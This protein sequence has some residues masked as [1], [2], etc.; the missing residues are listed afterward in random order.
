MESLS[1]MNEWMEKYKDLFIYIYIYIR[2]ATEMYEWKSKIHNIIMTKLLNIIPINSTVENVPQ[3]ILLQHIHTYTHEEHHFA[4][5][6]VVRRYSTPPF[7]PNYHLAGWLCKGWICGSY[8]GERDEVKWGD[9]YVQ[10]LNKLFGVIVQE[11]EQEE[12]VVVVVVSSSNTTTLYVRLLN[13][14]SLTSNRLQWLLIL[15]KPATFTI[16]I[17]L[18]FYCS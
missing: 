5:S 13:L 10:F 16:A 7:I 18:I 9:G 2:I 11:E 15:W 3:I 12:E 17:E 1:I 4:F 6:L 14:Y 8:R